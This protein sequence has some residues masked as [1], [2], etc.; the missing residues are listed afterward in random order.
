MSN[1]ISSQVN[2]LLTS[3]S[4]YVNMSRNEALSQMVQ[5]GVITQAQY[6]AIINGTIFV[7]N[8][9]TS[10]QEQTT[11]QLMGAYFTLTSPTTQTQLSETSQP[12][13]A[14]VSQNNQPQQS[15]QTQQKRFHP[16]FKDLL[17][18]SEGKV[19][20]KQFGI[21]ALKEK[22]SDDKYEI[23][24]EFSD[25]SSQ[26]TITVINKI[27]GKPVEVITAMTLKFAGCFYEKTK[28]DNQGNLIENMSFIEDEICSYTT[29]TSPTNSKTY[30][31]NNGDVNDVYLITSRNDK[32]EVETFYKDGKITKRTVRNDKF[33]IVKEEHFL[34]GKVYAEYG[35][36]GEVIK[37]FLMDSI[38]DCF[39]RKGKLE[40][41]NN[42]DE[43]M[44]GMTDPEVMTFVAD[45]F[46]QKKGIDIRLFID[47][48]PNMDNAIKE[49]Y[50]K[51]IDEL[52]SELNPNEG[53]YFE[54]RE[55]KMCESNDDFFENVMALDSKNI[56]NVL[57]NYG[58][59][60]DSDQNGNRVKHTDHTLMSDINNRFPDGEMQYQLLCH[61]YIYRF[62]FRVQKVY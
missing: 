37:N 60:Y 46:K 35:K 17:L 53:G 47:C 44:S 4:R 5:D 7:A 43:I 33:E 30:S 54:A 11:S 36:D 41:N 9:Q 13:Q 1:E 48:C 23:I 42:L 55:L 15:Q 32:T 38:F 57:L 18:T 50:I 62:F 29:Y 21:D 24:E 40:K 56:R 45:A 49:K 58:G 16:M 14:Q 34:N 26:N 6:D 10:T 20:T 25:E 28:Y 19:D 22:Y 3:D 8:T 51:Q 52:L 12:Q 59:L 27:T 39:T 2:L 61:H 31:Y